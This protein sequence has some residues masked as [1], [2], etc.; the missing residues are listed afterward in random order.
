MVNKIKMETILNKYKQD[1][2][3]LNCYIY[4]SHIYKSNDEFSDIDL[5]L[6]VKEKQISENIDIH[7]FTVEEFQTLLN[8]MDIKA[9]ECFFII[10]EFKFENHIFTFNY[11]ESNLRKSISTI[12]NNSWVKSKKKITVLGD[13]DLRCGLKSLFHSI[14]I[15]DYGI[16]IS[17][18][19]KI[20]SFETYS[21]ILKD[22]HKLSNE[23]SFVDLWE[24]MNTKYHPL[25]KKLKSEFKNNCKHTSDKEELNFLNNKLKKYNVPDNVIK[26]IYN[27]FK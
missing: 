8:N 6:I 13:Y 7:I 18:Y 5:I 21:Y 20:I 16:Q 17:K 14:R 27:Y 2:N 15:L 1:N 9:L 22:L 23:F 25:F 4:G 26:E 10:D 24:K 3:I 11:N 19:K 12:S